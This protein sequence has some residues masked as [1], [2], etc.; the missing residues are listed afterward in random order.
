MRK[1]IATC[2]WSDWQPMRAELQVCLSSHMS[3]VRAGNALDAEH[4]GQSI[5]GRTGEPC[6]IREGSQSLDRRGNPLPDRRIVSSPSPSFYCHLASLPYRPSLGRFFSSFSTNS[7]VAHSSSSCEFSFSAHDT[8]DATAS[9]SH[10]TVHTYH[11]LIC[12]VFTFL[13]LR[14]DSGSSCSQ[15]HPRFRGS[16]PSSTMARFRDNPIVAFYQELKDCTRQSRFYNPPRDFVLASRLLE[17]LRERPE[18]D[19]TSARAMIILETVYNRR[20]PWAGAWNYFDVSMDK[21]HRQ[22][23]L[24]LLVILL[25]IAPDGSFARLLHVFNTAEIWD[26]KLSEVHRQES[27]LMRIVE[28]TGIYSVEDC[29]DAVRGF[30]QRATELST[31]KAIT[32][33]HGRE[34]QPHVLLPITAKDPID[35]GGQSNVFRIEVPLECISEEVAVYLEDLHYQARQDDH[36]SDG[37]VFSS[38]QLLVCSPN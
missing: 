21:G 27:D 20:E 35:S 13:P 25:Q 33:N 10:P 18:E 23:W 6:Q 34:L 24:K 2:E 26:S 37:K 9:W 3:G 32:L 16:S 29:H 36:Y 8:S 7:G 14:F 12:C 17:W 30:L 38:M 22:C 4:Q 28:T 11:T 19:E 15:Q 1:S 31:Q 5:P